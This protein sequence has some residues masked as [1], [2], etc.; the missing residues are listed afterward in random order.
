MDESFQHLPWGVQK[1][2]AIKRGEAKVERHGTV[3]ESIGVALSGYEGVN[4]LLPNCKLTYPNVSISTLSGTFRVVSAID[5][6]G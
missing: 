3:N 6:C 5:H 4:L 1:R 2:A